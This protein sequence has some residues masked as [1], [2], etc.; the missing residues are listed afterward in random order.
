[1]KRRIER[2]ETEAEKVAGSNGSASSWREVMLYC[3][4]VENLNREQQGLLHVPLTPEEVT[5]EG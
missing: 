2:L 3:K 5:W 1:M 4:E